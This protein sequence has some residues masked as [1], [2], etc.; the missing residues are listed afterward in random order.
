M[1]IETFANHIIAVAHK[2]EIAIDKYKLQKV[3]YLTLKTAKENAILSQEEL[4]Q[5]Y[6]EPF[7][8]YAYGPNLVSQSKRFY[9]FGGAPIIGSN[10]KIDQKLNKLNPIIL[11]YL[12]KSVIELVKKS[13]ET[14]FW[15][16][17]HQYLNGFTSD[18]LYRLK[19]L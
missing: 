1:T 13:R 5:I 17:N 7:V 16:K 12:T 18:V 4:E 6:D 19:D 11:D 14:T 2:N 15:K 10:F 9:L 8:L 3:M